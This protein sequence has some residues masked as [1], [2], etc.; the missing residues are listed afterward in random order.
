MTLSQLR[1]KFELLSD[2]L[3]SMIAEN[4]IFIDWKRYPLSDP[5]NTPVFSN[6]EVCRAYS[7]AIE[8]CANKKHYDY[9]RL[10]AGAKILWDGIAYNI[11]NPGHQEVVLEISDQ[12]INK[13]STFRLSRD[14]FVEY[15][16]CGDI[17]GIDEH[18]DKIP[19]EVTQIFSTASPEA[20]KKANFRFRAID[21]LLRGSKFP[22][23]E[24]SSRTLRHWLSKYKKAEDIYDGYGF[25]G[26]IDRSQNKGNRDRKIS[27]TTIEILQRVIEEEYENTKG[28]NYRTVYGLLLIEL[29][30]NGLEDISYKTFTNAI[31][32]RKSPEQTEK[33]AG[34]R[35]AYQEK[36][37]EILHLEWATPRHGSYPMSIVHIDHTE[38]D[39]VLISSK[40][41]KVLGRPWLTLATC[42]YSRRILA[43][44]LSFNSPSRV[45]CMMI[46]RE[47]VR[48]YH[49]L[50]KYFVV[51][52]G[53][54]FGS[55]YFETTTALFKSI[56]AK[57]PPGRPRF[58][59]VCER[60]FGTVNTQ[61]IHNLVGNTKILKKVR[62]V[63]KSVNPVNLAEW[64]LNDLNIALGIYID[65]VY[66]VIEHPAL[67][68]L[69]P[70]EAFEQG[71]D[72]HGKREMRLIPYDQNFLDLTLVP[73]DRDTGKVQ[74]T[75]GIRLN[76]FDYWCEAF[77]DPRVMNT[78][79]S[80][81]FD[82]WDISYIKA[83][84]KGKWVTCYSSHK[85]QLGD[86]TAKEIYLLTQ[87]LRAQNT[88]KGRKFNLTSKKIA[89]ALIEL[90]QK[91]SLIA[92]QRDKD[93]EMKSVFGEKS[94]ELFN[95]MEFEIAEEHTRS[96]Q[97]A[98][99]TPVISSDVPV[100]FQ[101]W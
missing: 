13:G 32:A 67:L 68:G 9:P 43:Y 17:R 31:K 57:R 20:I 84:V 73:A 74:P 69:S 14:R 44:Y 25:I 16:Q 89:T 51:D 37:P 33:I 2:D 41:G 87:E 78:N 34:R 21:P 6:L 46:I 88:N 8:R 30:K 92:K 59:S 100:N 49:K 70:K 64:T 81:R 77:R 23:E 11:I 5:D 18:E 38:L 93:R 76:Y 53:A 72:K 96:E 83:Y 4:Q 91:Q 52:N 27:G 1:I 48:K 45:S 97:I 19:E 86:R 75:T 63:T 28:R 50:P 42:T 24:V 54:E 29:E 98:P 58:G 26:L 101:E 47:I 61:F 39:I 82:P 80:I 66:D 99:Y 22:G 56:I 60:I 95:K 62:M 7:A 3:L 79:V 12:S 90:E 71:K 36:P 94:S 15:V 65:D 40:T 85:S 35:A 10:E 55:D